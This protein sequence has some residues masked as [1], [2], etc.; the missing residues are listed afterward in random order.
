MKSEGTG[1]ER[2]SEG[3]GWRRRRRSGGRR[4][5]ER[6]R[7]VSSLG[8][9]EK[10]FRVSS[11]AESE[12]RVLFFNR[13]S[14]LFCSVLC[15]GSVFALFQQIRIYACAS[16]TGSL[17]DAVSRVISPICQFCLTYQL[18]FWT[19]PKIRVC[20]NLS[21]H[22][23]EKIHARDSQHCCIFATW[24]YSCTAHCFF[25][26][27]FWPF[28]FENWNLKLPSIHNILTFI[29]INFYLERNIDAYKTI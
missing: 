25:L 6:L 16:R 1:E 27:P 11:R 14:V 15:G 17:Y 9:R 5:K 2:G 21:T 4:L 26:F 23:I 20:Q 18:H 28:S 7:H 19:L 8:E 10:H 3:H 29:L 24:E 12:F 22:W 13:C